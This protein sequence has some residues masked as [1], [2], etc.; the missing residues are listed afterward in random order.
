VGV[1]VGTSAWRR[2]NEGRGGPGMAV[3]SAGQPAMAP[4]RRVWVALLP[5]EQ[6]SAA[7]MDD[8]VT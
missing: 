6:S 2:E 4:S 3:S 1:G 7:G 8:A 5:H